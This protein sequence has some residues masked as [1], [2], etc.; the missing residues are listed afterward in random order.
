MATCLVSGNE[1]S[2]LGVDHL[3]DVLAKQ[4]LAHALDIFDG[5]TAESS[6]ADLHQAV[7]VAA[8]HLDVDALDQ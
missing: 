4:P 2:R 5:A 8:T 1:C 7:H 3:R 6:H